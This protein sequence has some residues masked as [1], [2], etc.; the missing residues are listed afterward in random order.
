MQ[1]DLNLL[2]RDVTDAI[3][4]PDNISI[5]I[6]NDLPVIVCEKTRMEQVFQ[7]LLSNAVKYMNK[8]VGEVKIGCIDEGRQWKFSVA[9]NGSGIEDKYFEKIFQLFQQATP[10]DKLA[11]PEDKHESTGLGLTIVKKIVELYGGEIRV[12][13]EIGKGSTFFFTLCKEEIA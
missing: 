9:D 13:S 11:T 8:P 12:E 7:N 5:T 2:V 1:V 3:S 4:P 10:E 6:N